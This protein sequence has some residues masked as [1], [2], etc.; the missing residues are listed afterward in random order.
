[1]NGSI[2]LFDLAGDLS[3]TGNINLRTP[4]I[5][6]LAGDGALFERFYVC[7]VCSPTRA[8]FLTGRYHPRGGVRG[9]TTGGERLDLD[10]KTVADAFKAAGYATVGPARVR[11]EHEG[12]IYELYVT[13][14]HQGLGFGE[15]LFEACRHHLDT[16]QMCGLLVWA[17]ADNERA[18]AFYRAL[19][20]AASARGSESFSGTTL[21]KIAFVWA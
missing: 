17:L 9:V 16:R 5:D 3:V 10:E 7:P 15:R 8:E 11:G 18:C 2:E 19:G 21:D 6:S 12:E 13:P 14:T 20:G 4:N 1:M